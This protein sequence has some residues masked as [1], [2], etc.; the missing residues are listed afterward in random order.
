[1][2]SNRCSFIGLKPSEILRSSMV[3]ASSKYRSIAPY[4]IGHP[5]SPLIIRLSK[6]EASKGLQRPDQWLD[7]PPKYL[8]RVKEGHASW[9]TDSHL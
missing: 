8:S 5:G 9:P 3:I 7:V 1:M 4:L 2:D 6:S